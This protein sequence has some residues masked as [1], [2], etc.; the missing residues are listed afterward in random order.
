MR[1]P[2]DAR[3]V[4][5]VLVPLVAATATVLAGARP[6]TAVSLRVYGTAV[7]AGARVVNL[8]VPE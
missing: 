8:Q 5:P 6:G 4:A 7:P 2:S 3:L 1:P